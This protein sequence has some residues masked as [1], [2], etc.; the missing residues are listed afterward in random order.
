MIT[1]KL[2]ENKNQRLAHR[3]LLLFEQTVYHLIS[4]VDLR[5]AHNWKIIFVVLR[6]GMYFLPAELGSGRLG[7]LFHAFFPN[8]IQKVFHSK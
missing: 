8:L 4:L 1:P 5:I 7:E 3:F 2:K 6:F